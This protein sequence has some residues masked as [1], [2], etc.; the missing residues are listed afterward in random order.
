M[1]YCTRLETTDKKGVTVK[2][3]AELIANEQTVRMMKVDGSD[4]IC[5]TDIAR[6]KNS[7]FPADVVRNWSMPF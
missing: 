2:K 7:D 5:L 4:F 6:F 1:L 3:N